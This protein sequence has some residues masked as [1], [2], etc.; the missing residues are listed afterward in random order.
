MAR[1]GEL[2]YLQKKLK[3]KK[4]SSIKY[5][6]DGVKYFEAQKSALRSAKT[7]IYLEFFTIRSGKVLSDV[8]DILCEKAKSGVEVYFLYDNIGSFFRVKLSD[9]KRL[10][11][12]GVNFE[13]SVPLKGKWLRYVNN[14]D[15]RKIIVIDDKIA[16]TGGMNL[17]DEYAHITSPYG[18]WKDSG[19]ALT[20][21]IVHSFSDMFIEM[22]NN[23]SKKKIVLVHKGTKNIKTAKKQNKYNIAAFASTPKIITK[24]YTSDRLAKNIYINTINSA[25]KSL[26]LSTPYLVCDS[27]ILNSLTLAAG[28]GVR[29]RLITP[30][31]P[32]HTLVAKFGRAN[33]ARLI[34]AGVEI[35]E[36][37]PGIIHCKNL[38]KDSMV[39]I[40]GTI[41]FDYRSF[42]IDYECA[43][44]TDSKNFARTLMHDF[45]KVLKKSERISIETY[46]QKSLLMFLTSILKKQL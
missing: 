18:F 6:D 35:Y 32:D 17:S 36:F 13:A 14:R 12:S 44:W 46:K 23:F 8:I 34:E 39:S 42:D 7:F 4:N 25:K 1:T 24:K 27:E 21:D 3:V 28:R 38:I 31:N 33:Y 30:R 40:S 2:V 10:I 37:L 20:G 43:I 19:L 26:I 45:N 15:H 22:W 16:F 41:N 9:R 11:S 29:V 5:F